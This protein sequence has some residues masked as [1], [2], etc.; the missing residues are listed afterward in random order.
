MMKQ[1]LE[2]VFGA[3]ELGGGQAGM[4]VGRQERIEQQDADRSLCSELRCDSRYQGVA[5]GMPR[6]VEACV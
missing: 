3:S 1:S 5:A 6:S 2:A 4:F